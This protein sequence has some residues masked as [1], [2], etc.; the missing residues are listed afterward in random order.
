[1]LCSARLRKNVEIKESDVMK[2]RILFL[3]VFLLF[4]LGGCI[5]PLHNAPVS[6]NANYFPDRSDDTESAESIEQLD[7]KDQKPLH[8]DNSVAENTIFSPILVG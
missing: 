7:P 4:L 6:Q 1:M 3:P 5:Q 2:L 8:I